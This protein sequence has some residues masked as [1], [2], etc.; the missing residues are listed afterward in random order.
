VI[1]IIV[2]ITLGI[3]LVE[4]FVRMALKADGG[5][6]GGPL[7]VPAMPER[8]QGIGIGLGAVAVLALGLAWGAR[9]HRVYLDFWPADP[10]LSSVFMRMTASD[11]KPFYACEFIRINELRGKMFNYWTEG[12][13]IAWGQDPDPETGR[14]P[15]RLFMDG[16]AQAAYDVRVFDRWTDIMSGGPLVARSYATGGSLSGEEYRQVG[17]WVSE[18]LRDH[19]VWVVLMPSNQ[20]RKPFT[21]GLEYSGDWQTVFLNNKQKLFVDIGSPQGLA[22]YQ[23]VFSGETKYPDD[24]TAKLSLGHN[25][26]LLQEVAQK[27]RGLELIIEAFNL[28]PSAAPMM[29]MLLIGSRYAALQ[30]RIDAFCAEYAEEFEDNRAEYAR[31]DGYNLRLEA[32]RLALIRLEQVARAGGDREQAEVYRKRRALYEGEQA[33]VL[34]SKRW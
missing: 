31:Q 14:T 21:L 11:A 20:F 23:G 3:F 26:L 30:P 34:Y 13:F 9:F 10:R 4:R 15:L 12:G 25:L 27:Q 6:E 28:Y 7:A 1:A 33:V 24:F 5:R 18:Q 8:F 2:A 22:L 29:E 16:R 19:D 32:A 17:K